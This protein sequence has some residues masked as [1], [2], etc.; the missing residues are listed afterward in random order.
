MG[1]TFHQYCTC[2][3]LPLFM[4]FRC[5]WLHWLFVPVM[6]LL[7]CLAGTALVSRCHVSLILPCCHITT[8]VFWPYFTVWVEGVTLTLFLLFSCHNSLI[9]LVGGSYVSPILLSWAPMYLPYCW[10]GPIS[11]WSHHCKGSFCKTD[12]WCGE[13]MEQRSAVVMAW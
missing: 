10:V 4:L 11:H 8:A 3:T 13:S 12:C 5:H 2:A 7:Y 9:M 6:F 1:A